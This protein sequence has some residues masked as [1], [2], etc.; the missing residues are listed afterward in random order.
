VNAEDRIWKCAKCNREPVIQSKVFSYL[1]HNVS[2][3]VLACP[4][5]GKVFISEELAEGK[6]AEVEE[7]LE[8]K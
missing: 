3:E 1:G 5:C 6:M 4:R 7:Q 2:H 8:E